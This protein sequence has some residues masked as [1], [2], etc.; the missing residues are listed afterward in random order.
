MGMNAVSK[1]KFPKASIGFVPAG[2]CL[3][4]QALKLA[5]KRFISHIRQAFI[6]KT[7]HC[8][9]YYRSITIILN[10]R[11]GGI[12]PSHRPVISVTRQARHNE[13]FNPT[14]QPQPEKRLHITIFRPGSE[15][16]HIRQMVFHSARGSEAIERVDS[17]LRI[18]QPQESKIP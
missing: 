16:G 10:L 2:F 7:L 4:T 5:K 14:L 17:K 18:S 12:S 8:C 6:K 9:Q 15:I 1:S 13:F 11:P 3:F